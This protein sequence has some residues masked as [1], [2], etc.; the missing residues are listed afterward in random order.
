MTDATASTAHKVHAGTIRRK[1]LKETARSIPMWVGGSVIFL[2]LTLWVGSWA[3]SGTSSEVSG[4]LLPNGSCNRTI[5]RNVALTA[6][7][8]LINAN[9]YQCG[10]RWVVTKGAMRLVG[11]AVPFSEQ[12]PSSINGETKNGAISHFVATTAGDTRVDY[13]L[14][15]VTH[16]TPGWC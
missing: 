13:Q 16:T 7:P 10:V 4:D 6:T 3:Y 11:P 5:H 2:L 8:L 9:P 1:Q 14:C 12:R 15:P